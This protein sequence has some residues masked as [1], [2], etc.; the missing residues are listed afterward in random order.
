MKQKLISLLAALLALLMLFSGCAA[1]G[2]TLIEAGNEKISINVFQLYL[3]RMKGTLAAAGH[4]VN[5]ADFWATIEHLNGVDQT[6]NQYFTNQVFEGL[7]QIAAALCLYDELGLKLDPAV[8]EEID[9]WIDTLIEEVGQGSKSQFNSV[10]SA[11]G[12]NVTVLRD[13]AIIEAKLDQLKAEL[14]G[15]EGSLVGSTKKEQFYKDTY[16]R[17]YQMLLSNTYYDHDKD[18]DGRMIYYK[19]NTDGNLIQGTNGKPIVAYDESASPEVVD[20]VTKYYKFGEI[21]YDTEQTPKTD[22]RGNFV[23]DAEG[24]RIY[25]DGNGKVAYDTEN[26]RPATKA[27]EGATVPEVDENGN[28]VYRKWV[29]AYD[30]VHGKP[31]YKYNAKGEKVLVAYTDDQMAKRYLLAEQIAKDCQGNAALFLEYMKEFGENQDFN[32]TYAPNGMYFSAG[33]YTADTV[34][35]TFS[36]ELAKM[37]IGDLVILNSD[38]G[39]YILMRSELDDGAWQKEENSR[40]FS[41]LTPLVV[42]QMLQDKLKAEGYLDRVSVNEDL[43]NSVDIT[44]VAA[45]NYY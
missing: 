16:Y 27:Q 7:K 20:G 39:Y 33:V 45:N 28:T 9:T 32:D 24:N 12:A 21:A 38:S 10:L 18:S 19:V 3:S 11:Y 15:A 14:Y 26:G 34:F 23:R 41:S 5:D 6:W 13:A 29:V 2:K 42:E 22:E 37:E 31:N 44:M 8:E 25:V 43:K 35:S 40:W 30:T 4:D 36:T 17:G 1:H